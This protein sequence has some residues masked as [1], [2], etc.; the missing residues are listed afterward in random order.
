MEKPASQGQRLD[1]LSR[2]EGGASLCQI[3][4]FSLLCVSWKSRLT[5]PEF[6]TQLPTANPP[7]VTLHT[8]CRVFSQLLQ[9]TH[10]NFLKA[11]SVGLYCHTYR[12]LLNGVIKLGASLEAI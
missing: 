9:F 6:S 3:P 1:R 11:C 12:I 5:L 4:P 7:K 2:V 10:L 8:Y